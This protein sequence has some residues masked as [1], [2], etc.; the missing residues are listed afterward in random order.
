MAV[1]NFCPIK[2]ILDRVGDKWS[3]YVVLTLGTRDLMRFHE[4]KEKIHGIT[5]KMLTITLRHLEEDG[6]IERHY[7]AEIPPRVEYCLT[8]LG[9]SLYLQVEQLSKWAIE[10]GDAIISAR[11][12]HSINNKQSIQDDNI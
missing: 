8:P 6:L 3:I 7:Y 4:L 11:K 2:D 5:Q 10:N 9:K 1:E 12:K